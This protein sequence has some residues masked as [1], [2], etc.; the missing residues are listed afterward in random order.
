MKIKKQKKQKVE[1]YIVQSKPKKMGMN[2]KAGMLGMLGNVARNMTNSLEDPK[3]GRMIK[4]GTDD[5]AK[6]YQILND[7]Y[8]PQDEKDKMLDELIGSGRKFEDLM[9]GAGIVKPGFFT[10]DYMSKLKTGLGIFESKP[11]AEDYYDIEMDPIPESRP[12]TSKPTTSAG[13]DLQKIKSRF[14]EYDNYS[15][16]APRGPI[17]NLPNRAP[18]NEGPNLN[19]QDGF[20]NWEMQPRGRRVKDMSYPNERIGQPKTKAE[21]KALRA[22]RIS[23]AK[24]KIPPSVVKESTFEDNKEWFENRA[25]QFPK[26]S[27]LTPPLEAKA[28]PIIE[29]DNTRRNPFED[30][31]K[32]RTSRSKPSNPFEEDIE[33]KPTSIPPNP[34]GEEPLSRP[35]GFANRMQKERI[36]NTPKKDSIFNYPRQLAS[37]GTKYL[38]NL[39]SVFQLGAPSAIEAAPTAKENIEMKDVKPDVKP[40][41]EQMEIEDPEAV[42]ARKKAIIKRIMDRQDQMADLIRSRNRTQGTL[43]KVRETAQEVNQIT[44]DNILA[45]AQRGETLDSLQSKSDNLLSQSRQYRKNAEK[46]NRPWLSMPNIPWRKLA[47]YGGLGGAAAGAAAL[48]AKYSSKKDDKKSIPA[49]KITPSKPITPTPQ[50]IPPAPRPYVPPTPIGPAILPPSR[51][52]LVDVGYRRRY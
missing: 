31:S 45:A 48:A 33:M 46:L 8:M 7:K 20:E 41:I 39:K 17:I 25:K 2:K 35:S 3:G 18:V 28:K 27:K 21:R 24:K 51:S 15:K 14:E 9:I 16:F 42:K 11:F 1:G 10:G 37:K 26:N 38:K 36:L 40:K 12:T 4:S 52:R 50:P 34:F 13:P 49:S 29:E 5:Y 32:P 47:L 43:Q 22:N 30:E 23:K 19:W 44:A 6:F